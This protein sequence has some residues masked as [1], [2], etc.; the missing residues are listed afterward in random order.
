MNTK[1]KKG[2]RHTQ[3]WKGIGSST[4]EHASSL[5]ILANTFD[6]TTMSRIRRT[7]ESTYVVSFEH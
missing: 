2:H 5:M 4:L 7:P 1:E 6:A 3:Q